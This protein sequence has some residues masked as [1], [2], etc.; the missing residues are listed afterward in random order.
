MQILHPCIKS[1]QALYFRII[2]NAFG[3]ILFFHLFTGYLDNVNSISISPP[4]PIT[5]ATTFNVTTMPE[6]TTSTFDDVIAVPDGVTP[7]PNNV[8]AYAITTIGDATTVA[9]TQPTTAPV[10]VSAMMPVN[11]T[12]TPAHVTMKSTPSNVIVVHNYMHTYQIYVLYMH[13][14]LLVIT[15]L[16]SHILNVVILLL[17]YV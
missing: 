14:A 8:T 15:E 9:P 1:W 5:T 11:V 6:V 12:T 7:T 3:Q 17:S 13:K 4:P 16:R 10:N 2:I